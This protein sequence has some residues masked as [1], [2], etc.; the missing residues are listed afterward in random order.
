[1]RLHGD[2]NF[3]INSRFNRGFVRWLNG[4]TIKQVQ[5]PYTAGPGQIFVPGDD[6]G[7]VFVPGDDPGQIFVNEG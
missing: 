4:M 3:E 5:G 7:E 6:P 1:M 2:V